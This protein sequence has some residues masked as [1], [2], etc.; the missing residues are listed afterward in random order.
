A[1]PFAYFARL[2]HGETK[3][4]E[5][6]SLENNMIVMEILDAARQSAKTGKIVKLN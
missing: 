3:P 1:D 2:L 5:L 6:T 4:D